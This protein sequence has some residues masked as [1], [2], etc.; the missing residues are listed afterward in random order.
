MLKRVKNLETLKSHGNVKARAIALDLLERSLDACDPYANTAKLLRL[1][2]DILYAGNPDFEL[3]GDPVRGDSVIDMKEIDRVFIFGWGKGIQRSLKAV[4]DILGDRVSGGHVVCKHGD[5]IILERVGVTPGGHPVPDEDGVMGNRRIVEICGEAR[6]TERDLVITA[7]CS[8]VSALMTYPVDA[9]TL[10][11]VKEIT[12]IMQIELGVPTHDLNQIRNHLDRLKGGRINRHFGKARIIHMAAHMNITSRRDGINAYE[13]ML[14][15]NSWM[16]TFPDA[17]DFADAWDVVKKWNVESRLPKAAIEYLR[18]A[19][20]EDESMKADEFLRYSARCFG[21]MP[22]E[23][24]PVHAAVERAKTLGYTPYVLV[25]KFDTE[26]AP[27]AFFTGNMARLSESE[28]Q[29]FKP[30]CALISTGESIVSVGASGGIGGRNQ[31]YVLSG[32]LAIAG[33]KR[34]AMASCDTDGTDG[35]GGRFDDAAW[36]QGVRCL[37]GGIVDGYTVEEARERGVDIFAAIKTHD[38]SRALWKLDSGVH[39]IQSLSLDDIHI[40]V[41]MDEDGERV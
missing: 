17:K 30:P 32:A 38:T 35:P 6:F 23:S 20:P 4:E 11:E 7:A 8:G 22:T 25:R 39:A 24:G 27:V 9:V 3:E 37:C 12:R 2:G 19:L 40:T 21:I 1:E 14:R 16:H 13:L 34:I 31:E 18:K 5:D 15:H 36:E 26:P 41:I 28:G 10:D 33:S 29:P